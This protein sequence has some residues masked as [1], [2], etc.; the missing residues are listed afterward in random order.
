MQNKGGAASSP[1]RAKIGLVGGPDSRSV[2]AI[3]RSLHAH[4][5][6]KGSAAK[7]RLLRRPHPTKPK[8]GLL[9]DPDSRF[10]SRCPALSPPSPL[11]QGS[12][13]NIPLVQ[14][15]ILDKSN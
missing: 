5:L 15:T 4:P 9:G 12:H 1:H 11:F 2:R 10:L 13:P 6:S 3:R 7:T 8:S 14:V